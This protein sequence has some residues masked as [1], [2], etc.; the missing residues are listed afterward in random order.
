RSPVD[1]EDG[2]GAG[3]V[4]CGPGCGPAARRHGQ[5]SAQYFTNEAPSMMKLLRNSFAIVLLACASFAQAAT[6]IVEVYK[7]ATCGCCTEWIKHLRANGFQV[8]AH[9]VADPASYR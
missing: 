9:D 1:K 8:N 5:S 4:A 7:S 3:R 6:P 2:G